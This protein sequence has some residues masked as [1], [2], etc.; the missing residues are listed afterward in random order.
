MTKIAEILAFVFIVLNLRAVNLRADIVPLTPNSNSIVQD[1]IEYY[2]QTDKAVYD[3]GEYVEILHRVTNLRDENVTF[4]FANIQQC[5][6]SVWDGEI[7]V[8]GWPKYINPALSCFTLQPE[9]FKEYSK[10]WDMIGDNGLLISPGIYDVSGQLMGSSTS[11]II[12][13]SV[14]VPIQIIPEPAAFLLLVLGSLFLTGR[15]QYS[16]R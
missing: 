13:E 16:R 15:C 3:L 8:W 11:G 4:E 14:S 9:G 2:T 10:E 7:R 1:G 12:P 6:F 5:A